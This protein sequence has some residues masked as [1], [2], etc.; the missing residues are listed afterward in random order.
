MLVRMLSIFLTSHLV[1]NPFDF[2]FGSSSLTSRIEQFEGTFIPRSPDWFIFIV[3]V[4][5]ISRITCDSLSSGILKYAQRFSKACEN[6]GGRYLFAS[7]FST[8]PINFL[9]FQ[10]N[11]SFSNIG[12]SASR[13]FSSSLVIDN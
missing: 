8:F 6:L 3:P 12:I 4:L 5:L 11:S 9:K 7:S 10:P 2:F 13:F 1:S